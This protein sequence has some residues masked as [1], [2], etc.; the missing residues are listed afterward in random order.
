MEKKQIK[1]AGIVCLVISAICIFI[2][3]ERYQTANDDRALKQMINDDATPIGGM[4]NQMTGGAKIKATTPVATK[5]A[6]LFAVV[7]GGAGGILLVKSNSSVDE[8]EHFV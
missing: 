3:V 4:M 1:I 7:T 6:I 8:H 2:A 5:Y